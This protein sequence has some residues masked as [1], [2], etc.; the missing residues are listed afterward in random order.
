[1]TS[2]STT[3]VKDSSLHLKG[4][5]RSIAAGFLGLGLFMG[6]WGV[7]VPARSAS[8]G[9]T[10]LM[11][12]GFLLCIGLS[13]CA[14]IYA[15]NRLAA[16]QNASHLIR[17]AAPIYAFGFAICL[18]TDSLIVFFGL[19]LVTGF[20]AGLIDAGL[21]GQ[22]SQ[23]EQLADKRAMSFFHGLWSLGVLGGASLTTVSLAAGIDL[24]TLAFGCALL[25][26]TSIATRRSWIAGAGPVETEDGATKDTAGE[27]FSLPM[28]LVMLLGLC[29]LLATL[30]EG[31]I[32]DWS[33]LH[34]NQYAGLEVDEAGYAVIW[35]SVAMT[36]SRF[37][38][39]WLADHVAPHLLLA[40]P[41]LGAA[42]LLGLAALSGMVG[43]LLVAYI[44][45]GLALGNA[46][47]IVISEAGRAAGDRPLRDISVIVAFAYFGLISGPALLGLLAH[48]LNL[49]AIIYAL[50]IF[51]LLLASATFNLPRILALADKGDGQG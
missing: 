21:N 41:M 40:V 39:D 24:A 29:I 13:L 25:F 43:P 19:G 45:T 26:S 22:A 37:S 3:P 23:W 7:L 47:P 5:R 48:M 49:N 4:S 28:P 20:A 16:L 30:T 2:A 38:G 15:I 44:L 34:L 42:L 51:G 36:I 31:G 17:F 33:A 50:A 46:F 32:L 14:A 12:S 10:E 6:M 35:F 9:L 8:L 1:M 27:S 18:T 11:I